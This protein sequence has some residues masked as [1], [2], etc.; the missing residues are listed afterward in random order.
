[1]NTSMLLNLHH[2]CDHDHHHPTSLCQEDFVKLQMSLGRFISSNGHI[3]KGGPG[4]SEK[5]RLP[6]S[7]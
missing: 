7:G 2:G 4:V 3:S 6:G 5:L 1:M